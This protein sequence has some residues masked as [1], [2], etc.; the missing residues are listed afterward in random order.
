MREVERYD[1]AERVASLRVERDRLREEVDSRGTRVAALR[2]ECERLRAAVAEAKFSPLGDNH[3]NAAACPYCNP[4][5]SKLQAERDVLR[6]RLAALV[7]AADA[8]LPLLHGEPEGQLSHMNELTGRLDWYEKLRPKRDA[9]RAAL[10]DV[11]DVRER[12]REVLKAAW[13]PYDSDV[14][15]DAVIDRLLTAVGE[16]R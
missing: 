2:E 13:P 8:L 11:G 10:G 16:A 5:W 6:A 12:M 15:L 3:H 4:A 9:L 1:L 7:V 14:S